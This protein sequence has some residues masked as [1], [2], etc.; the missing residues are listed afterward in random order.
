MDVVSGC[1]REVTVTEDADIWDLL[2]LRI[3]Y[4]IVLCSSFGTN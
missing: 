3:Y 2:V 1:P 4:Q